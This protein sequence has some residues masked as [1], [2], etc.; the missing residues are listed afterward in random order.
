MIW[1]VKLDKRRSTWHYF[2]TNPQGGGFGSNHCGTKRHTLATAIRNIPVGATVEVIIN[3]QQEG[4]F[5]RGVEGLL[6]RP[7]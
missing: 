6:L 3:G 7:A 2:T 4:I 1:K 5:T